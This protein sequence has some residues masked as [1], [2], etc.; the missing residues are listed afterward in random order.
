MYNNI[1]IN[2]SGPVSA[3]AT[4]KTVIL[5]PNMVDGVN[6]LT[7]EMMNS[8]NTKYVIKHDF[9][10]TKNVVDDSVNVLSTNISQCVNPAYAN[11]LA[12]YNEAHD[13]WIDADNA[14]TNDPNET[15]LAAKNAAYAVYNAAQTT[16]NNTPQYYFYAAKSISIKK[17]N[18]IELSEGAV[19]L[20]STLNGTIEFDVASS[21][22][23][24]YIGSIIPGT[25]NYTVNNAIVIPSGCL[26]EFDGGSISDGTVI[27]NNTILIFK[28]SIDD[29]MKNIQ[30]DGA[31]SYSIAEDKP[32][33]D[34]MGRVILTKG[35]GFAEQ[36]VKGNTIYIIQYDFDLNGESVTIPA[37]CILEFDGGSLS[38]GT[39]QGYPT[40]KY[41]H[42]YILNNID[43]VLSESSAIIPQNFGAKLNGVNDDTEA[44]N[45]F[46]K[47]LFD[48]KCQGFANGTAL[49]SDTITIGCT[50]MLPNLNIKTS[51]NF[52]GAAVFIDNYRYNSPKESQTIQ[53]A[54]ND[55]SITLGN[56]IGNNN[57][58]VGTSGILIS[59]A[60]NIVLT[61]QSIESFEAGLL[62][63]SY[64]SRK[65][66]ISYNTFNIKRISQCKSGI[67]M[68]NT[69]R[70][71]SWGWINECQFNNTTI[72]VDISTFPEEWTDNE[73]IYVDLYRDGGDSFN[74][75]Q[76]NHLCL[77]GAGEGSDG[78]TDFHVWAIKTKGAV[79][80]LFNN[81]RF[82]QASN[83]TGYVITRI[84]DAL[85]IPNSYL[86][87]R[88]LE[89]NRIENVNSGYFNIINGSFSVP[90]KINY[91]MPFSLSQ[92]EKGEGNWL[93]G[94]SPIDGSIEYK[95]IGENTD[96]GIGICCISSFND[97]ARES[98]FMLW[99]PS[100]SNKI[101]YFRKGVSTAAQKEEIDS[102]FRKN[103]FKIV[104]DSE[105]NKRVDRT[106]NPMSSLVPDPYNGF[107]FLNYY[108]LLFYLNG[109][110]YNKEGYPGELAGTNPPTDNLITGAMFLKMQAGGTRHKPTW[111]SKIGNTKKWIEADGAISGVKRS[112]RFTDAPTNPYDIY[113]GFVFMVNDTTSSPE[114]HFPIFAH[115]ALVSSNP[116]TYGVEWYKAD[117]TQYT[118]S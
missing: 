98:N 18:H 40:I 79:S 1:N 88:N 3:P 97:Y 111:W 61:I 4:Y 71:D 7:Q 56:I 66:F 76:F 80:C 58:R 8:V 62:L 50:C 72:R 74:G 85:G 12:A 101:L 87:P 35:K 84:D 57:E 5:K 48:S 14:Y 91:L 30:L 104:M 68:R 107:I 113:E 10:L 38:N 25:Y 34:G 116:A 118:G 81:C 96:A 39:I 43:I 110:W 15:T 70:W 41:T 9:V 22:M 69:K 19:L 82:E 77:E 6:L 86:F 108:A 13:A 27:G 23:T 59:A 115:I 21:D 42:D 106:G 28:Q 26:I 46:F 51:S 117:G 112:G 54:I 90:N 109:T 92:Y 105:S 102:N 2:V 53:N 65:G 32:A 11:A 83:R 94:F 63:Q 95:P 75:H 78:T 60:R 47:V 52:T 93:K 33:G 73:A 67:K 29:V 114:K 17:Y 89:M 31:F 99:S 45:K 55:C 37:N 64:D 44:L 24:V 103:W 100:S 20:N 16:L 36:L 49:I